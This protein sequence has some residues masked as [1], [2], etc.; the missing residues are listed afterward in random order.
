L[1]HD[2]LDLFERS[3]PTAVR[4]SFGHEFSMSC[5]GRRK[6]VPASLPG[7]RPSR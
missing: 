4:T 1:D 2:V 3:V 5:R 7:H 6:Q